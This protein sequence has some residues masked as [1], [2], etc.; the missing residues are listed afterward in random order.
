MSTA[1]EDDFAMLEMVQMRRTKIAY[2]Q[3]Y[4]ELCQQDYKTKLEMHGS[5]G[6]EYGRFVL[7]L[8]VCFQII[9]RLTVDE[10]I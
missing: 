9:H 6:L 5:D 4:S 8:R 3:T 10:H 7:N 1:D 2:D